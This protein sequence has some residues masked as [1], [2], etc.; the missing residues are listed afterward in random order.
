[1]WADRWFIVQY[2]FMIVCLEPFYFL[3]YDE[4]QCGQ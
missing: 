1:M 2:D 3:E 4:R